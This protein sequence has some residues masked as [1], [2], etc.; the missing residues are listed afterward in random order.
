MVAAVLVLPGRKVC[1]AFLAVQHHHM[2]PGQPKE[3]FPG[4]GSLLLLLLLL[5]GLSEL[6]LL[7]LVLLWSALV[8][9]EVLKLPVWVRLMQGKHFQPVEQAD[10]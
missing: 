2:P 4:F 6:V 5:Q 7:L 1:V 10:A 3:V 8:L 9:Q